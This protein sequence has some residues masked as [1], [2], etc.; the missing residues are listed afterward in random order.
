MIH[1]MALGSRSTAQML[2]DIAIVKVDVPVTAMVA[3]A[4]VAVVVAAPARAATNFNFM[5]QKRLVIS[6]RPFLL[7]AQEGNQH[8]KSPNKT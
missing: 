8:A 7:S 6:Y 2:K 1:N 4:P 5:M 3:K